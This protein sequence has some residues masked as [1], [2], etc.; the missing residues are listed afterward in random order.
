MA[1][2]LNINITARDRTREAFNSLRGKLGGLSRAVFSLKGAFVGLG[3][4]IAVRSFVNTG[5]SIEDLQV[6]LKALF[7]TTQE[8]AKAFD[9]MANFA[10]KVPFSL[11][12]IQAASG[13]LAI[14]AGDSERLG[15]IL[16][17]TGNVAAATG[18]DFQ[19]TA[20]QIQR[21]FAG[22]IAAADVFRERGVRQMLG[23]KA[24]A[25]VTAEETIK[26]FEKVFGK[27]GKYGQVTD[28]LANT[29]TGTLSMLGD[30][31]FNFKRNVAGAQFFDELKK[32][33]KTLNKFIEEN[34]EDFETIANVIGKILTVAVKSFA[35]AVRGVAKAVSFLRNQYENLIRLLNKIPFVNIE[36][37][38]TQEAVNDKAEIY[39]DK[40]MLV[41]EELKKTNKSL[42]QVKDNFT[43]IGEVIKK[44]LDK[45]SETATFVSKILNM[46]IKGFSRGLAESIVM[47]KELKT[48]FQDLARTLLTEVLATIIEILAREAVLL[49]IE[50]AKTSE[51]KKQSI[52]RSIGSFFGFGGKASGG[53]VSKGQPVLVGEK[54]PEL[55]VPNQ[56]GQITQNARGTD[57]KGVTVNFNITTLDAS[58]FDDLLVR[59]RGTLTQIINTAVNERGE[60]NLI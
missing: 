20:E 13:N 55:F 42:V 29:F 8:G 4:G 23:F 41:N 48:T 3:A 14:V 1:Q 19:Q 28:D 49:A 58:G 56:T 38:K 54:G 34:T 2:N 17:I 30:K 6:R 39:K 47:G 27:G 57:G 46:G 9:V 43:K 15:K 33:F 52:F 10:A 21:S 36:I 53:A 26:A 32:E 24:G 60:R 18:L 5:R 51:I 22:G 12:Q 37:G 16:E 7:G 35:A 44:D 11:E 59:S 50:K 45:M 25:T 31:L 40:I